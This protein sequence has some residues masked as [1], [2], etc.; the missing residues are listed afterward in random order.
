MGVFYVMMFHD[1]SQ[2]NCNLPIELYTKLTKMDNESDLQILEFFKMS[3]YIG[4]I[5]N[6]FL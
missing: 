1:Q 6:N 2:F 4:F 3:S 5:F